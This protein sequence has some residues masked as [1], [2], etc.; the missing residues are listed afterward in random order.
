MEHDELVRKATAMTDPKD[1]E[2]HEP[3]DEELD[4]NALDEVSGG[5]PYLPMTPE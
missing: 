3:V 1:I 2:I 4:I 5:F